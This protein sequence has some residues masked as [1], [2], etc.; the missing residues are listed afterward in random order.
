MQGG[1]KLKTKKKRR[2]P[3]LLALKGLITEKESSYGKLAGVM[4]TYANV[5]SDKIN[6]YYNFNASEMDTICDELDIVNDDIAKYFF[7]ARLR[8]VTKVK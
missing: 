4:G 6:G 3:V 2:Y 8:N 1:D 7:P 5:I